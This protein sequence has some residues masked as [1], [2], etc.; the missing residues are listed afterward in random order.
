MHTMKAAL[1]SAVLHHFYSLRPVL[2]RWIPARRDRVQVE[3]DLRGDVGPEILEAVPVR[4]HGTEKH[5]RRA[6]DD[7]G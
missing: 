1:I 7:S 4:L 3:A 6:H 2:P 5:H